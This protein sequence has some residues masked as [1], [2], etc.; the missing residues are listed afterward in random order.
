[1]MC[2]SWPNHKIT[3]APRIDRIR[4]AGWNDEPSAGFEN[5]LAINPPTIDPIR[6]MII[7]SITFA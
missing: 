5:N 1:M 4:P 3:I 6:P 2:V 7:V